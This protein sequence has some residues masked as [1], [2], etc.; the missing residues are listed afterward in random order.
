MIR[1]RLTDLKNQTA[2]M[3]TSSEDIIKSMIKESADSIITRNL[4]GNDG[5]KVYVPKLQVESS[6][7]DKSVQQEG[8]AEQNGEQESEQSNTVSTYESDPVFGL[9]DSNK[10]D[11]IDIRADNSSASGNVSSNENIVD[12]SEGL[13]ESKP[14]TDN[15]VKMILPGAGSLS[16]GKSS[17][18]ENESIDKVTEDPE[19]FADSSDDSEKSVERSSDNEDTYDED[20]DVLSETRV[21][22]NT[23]SAKQRTICD[24]DNNSSF[25]VPKVDKFPK[26]FMSFVYDQFD[27]SMYGRKLPGMGSVL[28][29]YIFIKEGYPSDMPITQRVS[30]IVD[31]YHG[32]YEVSNA[33]IQ[34][35]LLDMT[36]RLNVEFNNIRQL[37]R[38]DVMRKLTAVELISLYDVFR[39]MNFSLQDN[40]GSPEEVNFQE[41]GM[42]EMQ[43]SLERQTSNK[44]ERDKIDN[45]H[46]VYAARYKEGH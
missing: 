34:E 31:L 13:S 21:I 11:T 44:L 30:D 28:A 3:E 2:D 26:N 15:R 8:N 43:K 39:Q 19:N 10:N 38:Q 35:K 40:V 25:Y 45:G 20:N 23:S 16:S 24:D 9:F 14:K 18:I 41:R 33:D 36:D 22:R 42:A 5:S 29:A 17:N 32:K 6:E 46:D 12:K 4:V 27:F 37:I 7:T 1:P